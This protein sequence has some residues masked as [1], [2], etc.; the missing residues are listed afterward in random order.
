[1]LLVLVWG[2]SYFCAWRGLDFGH[3][4]DE[5]TYLRFT[6]EMLDTGIFLPRWYGY[7]SVLFYL[8]LVPLLPE[9]L[10]LIGSTS[11]DQTLEMLR[12]VVG[13]TREEHYAYFLKERLVA[14]SLASLV[15]FWVYGFVWF[16]K[17]KA[18][19]AL[20]AATF[21][22]LSW[23]FIYHARWFAPDPVMVQ[24][25]A[26]TLMLLALAHRSQR[27]EPWFR[28]AVVAAGLACGTKYTG[29][30]LLVTV[31]GAY[32]LQV[33]FPHWKTFG[34]VAWHRPWTHS[35]HEAWQ[36]TRPSAGLKRESRRLFWKHQLHSIYFLGQLLFCFGITVICTTPGI[37]I[38]PITFVREL[39]I[40]ISVYENVSKNPY[41]VLSRWDHLSRI[42]LYLSS[43]AFS[44]YAVIAAFIF[45]MALIGIYSIRKETKFLGLLVLTILLYLAAISGYKILYVRNIMLTF[46]FFA[47]LASL[48]FGYAI[49]ESWRWGR[50]NGRP[51]PLLAPVLSGLLVL[52]IVMNGYWQWHSSSTIVYRQEN[53]S[54]SFL[55]EQALELATHMAEHPENTFFLS[56]RVKDLL[57]DN[58]D[59]RSSN[60]VIHPQKVKEYSHP[61][62]PNSEQMSHAYG[63]FLNNELGNLVWEMQANQFMK[64]RMLPTGPYEVNIDYYPS[65]AGT[66]RVVIAPMEILQHWFPEA[67]DQHL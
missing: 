3:H 44:R 48:G 47:I 38:D 15:V 17:K 64:Y 55:N 61:E 22:A 4:W 58:V 26:L 20:L 53:P 31:V 9:F 66:P 27:P 16:W 33:W 7:P 6:I 50:S 62:G 11:P 65:W 30:I 43:A 35:W 54:N 63:V 42:F 60:F 46:P 40:Q 49:R 45:G 34:S 32:C 28:L 23:E 36:Q 24:F 13:V 51:Y 19:E 8:S 25:A 57:D 18:W 59:Q 21:M 2:F 37:L 52:S 29:G 12:Q 1:M 5:F 56:K 67:M 14:M 39:A 41:M 10:A